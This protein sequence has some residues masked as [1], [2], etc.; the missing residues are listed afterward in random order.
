MKKKIMVTHNRILST[1]RLGY[2]DGL[3]ARLCKGDKYKGHLK[4]C[5]MSGFKEGQTSR[6]NDP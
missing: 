3:N 5:Y 6:D 2:N 4:K 1:W